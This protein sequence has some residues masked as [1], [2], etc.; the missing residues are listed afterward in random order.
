L[1]RFCT[2]EEVTI[3]HELD[4]ESFLNDLEH[5]A[6]LQPGSRKVEQGKNQGD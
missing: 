1:A 3:V 2:L 6:T 4:L 5:Y